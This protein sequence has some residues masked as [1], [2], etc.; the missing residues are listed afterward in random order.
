MELLREQ[1]GAGSASLPPDVD[2]VRKAE[3]ELVE[4]AGNDRCL[5]CGKPLPFLVRLK[6]GQFCSPHHEREYHAKLAETAVSRLA[7]FRVRRP[8][9]PIGHERRIRFRTPAQ[10]PRAQQ[11]RLELELPPIREALWVEA[12][13]VPALCL[14][15]DHAP[16]QC[17]GWRP[18]PWH[19]LPRVVRTD[20]PYASHAADW[21]AGDA[22][23]GPVWP[24][25]PTAGALR[26][27]G[28]DRS[29]CLQIAPPGAVR[30]SGLAQASGCA[31]DAWNTHGVLPAWP[32]VAPRN[33]RNRLP[34]A[35]FQSSTWHPVLCLSPARP[36]CS[37]AAWWVQGPASQAAWPHSP[38]RAGNGRIP[39]AQPH[40]GTWNAQRGLP[41]QQ[42]ERRTQLW[43]QAPA[44]ELTWPERR[45]R[46]GNG[47]I[48]DAQP[49]AGTWSA[50]RG[51]PPQQPGHRTQLWAQA[52][53]PELAWPHNPTRFNRR[54]VRQAQPRLG[55]W[56]AAAW[57]PAQP[58]PRGEGAWIH[59]A[60]PAPSP[61]HGIAAPQPAGAPAVAGLGPVR[62]KALKIAPQLEVHTVWIAPQWCVRQAEPAMRSLSGSAGVPR[63]SLE[64]R[65]AVPLPCEP[66]PVE[67]IARP[68]RLERLR[69]P[70]LRLRIPA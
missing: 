14:R 60:R 19:D 33:A 23:A 30:D 13:L 22:P 40:A 49:H 5:L 66:V 59:G 62:W 65:P 63:R 61:G 35:N 44:S 26:L 52:P 56:D 55:T 21:A 53:A 2:R 34:A 12:K 29:P 7:Q 67:E 54:S 24:A 50:Q 51:L 38:I 9:V 28:L 8:V 47:R 57:L 41:P 6:K 27:T 48:P 10:Q 45:I 18:Q 1:A 58:L 42:P 32:E 15:V 68:Q 3:Q 16:R 20:L 46:A 25:Q 36:T 4:Q 17:P 64:R 43:A 39:D 11:Q 31:P 70:S 37:P 69:L